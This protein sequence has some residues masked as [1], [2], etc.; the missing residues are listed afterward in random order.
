M[1]A[2]RNVKVIVRVAR[3]PVDDVM[4][5]FIAAPV[6]N[7]IEPGVRPLA[8]GDEKAWLERFGDQMARTER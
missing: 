3:L 8:P 1:S 4:V 2:I 5:A 6:E 7:V